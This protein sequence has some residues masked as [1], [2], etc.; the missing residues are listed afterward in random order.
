VSD[1]PNQISEIAQRILGAP[2]KKLSTRSQLRFG[3]NGSIAVDIQGPK[4]GT[5]FDHEIRKGGGWRELLQ[6]KGGVVD[7]DIDDWLDREGFYPAKPNGRAGTGKF[8]ISATY[9]YCDEAGNLLFQVCRLHPKTFRQRRPN[10]SGGWEW[11]TKGTRMVPYRLPELVAAA[12]N[13]NGA[14]PRVYITEGEKDA[15]RLA[16]WGLVATTNPGGA[17]KWPEDFARYFAGF[18]VVILG[19]NDDSG[20]AHVDM[21][22]V[23][24]AP[25]SASVRI[26]RLEGL[27]EKG[28]VSDWIDQGGTQS[29]LETLVDLTEPFRPPPSAPPSEISGQSSVRLDD[30]HAYMPSHSYIYVPSRDMWPAPSVNARISP[31]PIGTDEDGKKKFISAAAWLDRNRPVEQMTW[32]PGWPMIIKNRLVSL[33]GW[34]ERDQVSVFNLY[35]PPLIKLGKAAEAAPWINHVRKVYPNDAD[36]IICWLAHRVQ[37]PHEKINHAL[38]LGGVPNIGKDTILEPVKHAVGPWN[39]QEVSPRQILGRFNGFLKAVILR[40]SEARDLGDFDRFQFYEHMKTYTAAPPDV[41]RIDEKNHQEYYIP[42]CCGVVITTNY[43]TDG[44]HLPA[45]DRRHYVT[46]SEATPEDFE[47]GYWPSL[48]AWYEHGGNEHVAAYLALV[49]LSDFNPKAP[50]PKT[51]AFWEIVNSS[52]APENAELADV[53]DR[54][55]NPDILTIS[56]VISRS[57][58]SFADWLQ[59]RRNSRRIPHR[60]EDCGYVA[61]RNNHAKDGLWKVAGKRQAIY[62]KTSMTTRDRIIA[63]QR[64]AG[65]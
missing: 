60:L 4:A 63:A 47:P 7:D 62:G 31:I 24:L 9:D 16:E 52:R 55:G 34:I 61:V 41:H 40:V 37:L 48:Y 58:E 35:R 33:G 53:I 2:N 38:L 50:P 59:D 12:L 13:R 19:D 3:K 54:L 42:N 45:D 1:L 5:W 64:A 22:A 43:K 65:A 44:I 15:D 11:K 57:S 18:D 51:D 14:S 27:P 23:I 56:E 28:D 46:W 39:F 30:F 49:D 32:A 29:D 6:I 36:H 20:R 10:G 8:Y 25:V 17:G 21:V 26:P